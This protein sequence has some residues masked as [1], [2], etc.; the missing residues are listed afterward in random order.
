MASEIPGPYSIGSD[1]WPGLSRLAEEAAEVLQVVGKIIGG[2][3]DDIHDD[4]TDLRESLQD[5]LGDL[6]AAIDYVVRKNCL[7][8]D[9]V[10]RRRDTKRTLY[11][12]EEGRGSARTLADQDADVP[13]RGVSRVGRE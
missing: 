10:N 7:D 6:R 3:G 4:G 12:R 11:E 2:G 1:I 13:K 8:W 9:A 5:E